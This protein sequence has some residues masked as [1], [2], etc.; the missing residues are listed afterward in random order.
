[1]V[2]YTKVYSGDGQAH[3]HVTIGN[4]VDW[5]IPAEL[6]PNNTSGV[7]PAGFVYMR[8]TDTTGVLS[9]QSHTNRFGTEAFGGGYTSADLLTEPCT[10]NASDYHSFNSLS[11]LLQTDTTHYRDGT[12]LVPDG[13][14]PDVWWEETA[15]PGLNAD[16]TVQDQAIW[17]T[18]KHDYN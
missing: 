18:Y 7:S 13:P 12:D 10:N 9:C 15:V 1:M 17:F 14:M 8:G 5:D 2:L 6:V 3:N 4:S 16:A 11:Q